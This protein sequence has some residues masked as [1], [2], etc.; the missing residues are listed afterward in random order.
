MNFVKLGLKSTFL[1]LLF[2]IFISPLSTNA[3]GW[4]KKYTNLGLTYSANSILQTPD[5]GYAMLT[6]GY[7]Q[8]QTAVAN[9]LKTDADGVVQ[10]SKSVT[11]QNGSS[12]SYSNLK[13]DNIGATGYHLLITSYN[14]PGTAHQNLLVYRLNQFGDS[15]GVSVLSDPNY[16]WTGIDIVSNEDGSAVV[17]GYKNNPTNT[18]YKLLAIKFDANGD[19]SWTKVLSTSGLN[20]YYSKLNKTSDGNYCI[21]LNSNQINPHSVIKFDANGNV[22]HQTFPV[23]NGNVITNCVTNDNNMVLAGYN[24]VTNDAD[25]DTANVIKLDANGNKLWAKKITI[26][27]ETGTIT[28]SFYVTNTNDNNILLISNSYL[29]FIDSLANNVVHLI[30]VDASNGDIIWMNDISYA[31]F[32]FESQLK[33][34]AISQGGFILGGVDNANYP[35]MKLQI[36]RTNDAGQAY[37]NKVSGVV[38]ADLNSNCLFESELGLKNRI[39]RF[40]KGVDTLYTMSNNL[41]Q[42]S[43]VLDTGTYQVTLLENSPLWEACALSDIS[44][45]TFEN[46][47]TY[48]IPIKPLGVCPLLS[49]SSSNVRLRPCMDARY[50]FSYCN[51]G[52]QVASNAYVVITLDPLLTYLGCSNNATLNGLELTVDLGNV[53]IDECGEFYV[54]FNLSC[55]AQIS[56]TIC[57]TSEIFPQSPCVPAPGYNGVDMA[58]KGMCY[59]G[60]PVFVIKNLGVTPM[61]DEATYFVIEDDAMW[62][63]NGTVLLSAGEMYDVPGI[64]ANGATW[65]V[66]V[67]QPENHPFSTF[68]AAV[69]SGCGTDHPSVRNTN[70]FPLGDESP[71]VDELCLVVRNSY[72]PN[73]KIAYPEGY[74]EEHFIKPN[75]TIEYTVSF[76]NTGNDTAYVVV[77]KDAISPYLDLSTLKLGASSHPYNAEIL[78]GRILKFT[79]H[80]I[81]LVDSLTNERGSHGF[82]TFDIKQYDELPSG[83]LIEN[84]ADIYFDFNEAILTN[85]THHKVDRDFVDVTINEEI[86]NKDIQTLVSPNPFIT[87][88][89]IELKSNKIFEGASL[90]IFN[91]EGKKILSKKLIDNSVM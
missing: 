40:S 17:V 83:T 48:N 56:Q 1:L 70:L 59:G 31:N 87:E 61:T 18:D 60:I 80:D 6:N 2:V 4:I 11:S 19:T 76:Q 55:N 86:N 32:D 78:E 23:K 62:Q 21:N 25:L 29:N 51:E 82:V 45:S 24:F 43:T 38:F 79:F 28:P 91:V 30:K 34:V 65:R 5:G 49:L 14:V 88:T 81:N 33:A 69:V 16:N 84:R 22:I 50:H 46:D 57:T 9:I 77:I 73:E 10:W 67:P 20:Y 58:V 52:T 44:M 54:D 74:H 13:F 63:T 68:A 35:N 47:I 27:F 39:I 71:Y 53:G 8:T 89:K 42:F 26:P 41:G 7:N 12:P 64:T 66:E 75:K 85:T 90:N 37:S 36:M 15:I 3:Q 72:D